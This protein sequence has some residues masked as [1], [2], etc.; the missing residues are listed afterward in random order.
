MRYK[1]ITFTKYNCDVPAMQTMLEA[2]VKDLGD[3]CQ[4]RLYEN[5]ENSDIC[6]ELLVKEHKTTDQRVCLIGYTKMGKVESAINE[7]IQ[8]AEQRHFRLVS[9]NA[10]PLSESSRALGIVVVEYQQP[11]KDDPSETP[12]KN[13]YRKDQKLNEKSKPRSTS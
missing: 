3:I 13:P 2:Q 9:A 1:L 5:Q 11:P 7:K 6:L 8:E 10:L 4:A 12:E